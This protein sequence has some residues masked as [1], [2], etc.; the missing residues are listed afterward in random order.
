MKIATTSNNDSKKNPFANGMNILP[1]VEEEEGKKLEKG[2]YSNFSVYTDPTDNNSPK[3]EYPVKYLYGTSSLRDAI[4]F[5]KDMVRIIRG[6][7]IQT[8]PNK[9][10]VISQMIKDNAVKQLFE[11]ASEGSRQRRHQVAVDAAVDAAAA[12]A[13][14]T[15]MNN[16]DISQGM[17]AIINY[18]APPQALARVK[19]YLRRHCRKP[20]S[21]SVRQYLAR[22]IEINEGEIPYLPPFGGN[23]QCLPGDEIVDI[24]LFGCP[25]SWSKEL[26]RQGRD[27]MNMTPEEILTFFENQEQTED[28]N[29][30]EQKSN[31]NSNKDKKR[32]ASTGKK[33]SGGS[34]YCMHHGKN[35]THNTNDCKKL[36]AEVKKLKSN[37]SGGSDKK[38]FKN[39]TWNRKDIK[40]EINEVAKKAAKAVV[41]EMNSI[42]KQKKRRIEEDSDSEV[43]AIDQTSNDEIDE[44]MSDLQ[45]EDQDEVDC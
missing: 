45:L 16:D 19:R 28:Y 39:K 21:M 4:K 25:S 11:Q 22:I 14:R 29:W 20:P 18:Y 2:T 44:F 17:Q 9:L 38:P 36:Q 27:P 8:A 24:L 5:R 1:L 42:S 37:E 12:A 26:T 41:E 43:N 33:E 30:V 32:K 10:S 7:N 3:Y 40:K 35:N 6:L 34:F 15:D 23:A 31:S 13:V